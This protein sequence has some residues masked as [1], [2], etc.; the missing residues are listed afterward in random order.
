MIHPEYEPLVN[1]IVVVGVDGSGYNAA[2]LEWAES[3]TEAIKGTLHAVFAYD[4]M[5]DT[6]T[7]DEGWHVHSDDVRREVGKVAS[8]PVHLSMEPGHPADVLIQHALRERAA[9]V[10]TGTRGHGGFEGLV[11]GR[12]PSQLIAHCTTPLIVVPH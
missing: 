6:F 3:F 8:V 10:I 7:R 1:G 2:A 9:A 12:V 4:A 11:L 5:D